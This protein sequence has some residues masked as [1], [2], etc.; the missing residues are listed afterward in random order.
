MLLEAELLTCRRLKTPVLALREAMSFSS[1]SSGRALESVK[2]YKSVSTISPTMKDT[3]RKYELVKHDKSHLGIV[4][5]AETGRVS[6][7]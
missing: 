1:I 2:N 5:A 7:M 3:Q 6:L 4:K